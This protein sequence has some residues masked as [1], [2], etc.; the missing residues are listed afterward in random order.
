MHIHMQTVWSF[1]TVG[2]IC[3][4]LSTCSFSWIHTYSCPGLGTPC[5]SPF[6]LV[7]LSAVAMTR[8]H[9]GMWAM[10]QLQ[11]VLLDPTTW[12]MLSTAQGS[13][14]K[15]QKSFLLLC[16]QAWWASFHCLTISTGDVSNSL[17]R[18]CVSVENV[19]SFSMVWPFYSFDSWKSRTN[20][21][22]VNITV[23]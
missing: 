1:I 14:G 20:S 4:H 6:S 5:L 23:F 16:Y 15:V 3:P 17:C 19:Y 12:C 22:A 11:C 10:K 2:K 13:Q 9:M 8:Q 21:F 7:L 18:I